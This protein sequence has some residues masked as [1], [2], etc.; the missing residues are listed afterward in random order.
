MLSNNSISN[1]ELKRLEELKETIVDLKVTRPSLDEIFINITGT[2]KYKAEEKEE[3]DDQHRK[4][5]AG[6]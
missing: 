3:L 1:E 4:H 2:D 6:R 5:K